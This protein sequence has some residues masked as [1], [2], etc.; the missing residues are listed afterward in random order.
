MLTNGTRSPQPRKDHGILMACFA[1]DLMKSMRVVT[2]KLE[3]SLGPDTG[4]LDLRV[5]M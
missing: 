2:K 5:G 4:D 1:R 3:V